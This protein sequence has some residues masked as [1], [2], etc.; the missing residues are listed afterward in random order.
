MS[1]SWVHTR[2]DMATRSRRLGEAP[3][4]PTQEQV[5]SL[6]VQ[7]ARSNGTSV[8]MVQIIGSFHRERESYLFP[9]SITAVAPRLRRAAPVRLSAIEH[10]LG[11]V[12]MPELEQQFTPASCAAQALR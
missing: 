9:T 4:E 5:L 11:G 10:T 3:R 8:K 6:Q 12:T 2:C 1:P 7:A